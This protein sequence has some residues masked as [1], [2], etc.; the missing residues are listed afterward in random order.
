MNGIAELVDQVTDGLSQLRQ[1]LD[2][3]SA[4][5]LATITRDIA[6]LERAMDKKAYVDAAFAQACV[7]ADAGKL[8]GANHPDAYLTEKLGISRGEAYN[9][10]ARA[11]ALF[12]APPPPEPDLGDL[13]GDDDTEEDRSAAEE[14]AR[15]AA[16]EEAERRR[17]DQEEA[18]KRA[19]EVPAAKQDIIRRELD[20]LL[21]A[22]EGERMRIYAR[23][24]E[25]AK[26][27][28]EKDL[29]LFVKRLVAEA[30]KPHV[31]ANP[32]AGFEKRDASLGRE[33]SDGTFDVTLSMTR[34]DYA[35]YK[36]L[37]D[38]GLSP[39]ANIPAEL[40]RDRD[41]RTKGQRRYDQYMAILRQYEEGQQAAN[42]GAASVVVSITLDDLAGADANTLFQTNV[43]VELDAFD[44]VR[45]GMDGTSDF[46]L[47]VDG[48]SG[49]PLHLGRSRRL[50]SVG[51]R[52]AMFAVQG[53]CSWAGCT[54]SMSECEA[55][56]IISWLR[57]GATDIENLTGLCPT[58]HRCNNDHRD[59][60][61]NKGYMDYDP[62][63]GGAVLVKADGTRHT[64][65]TDPAMH[66][67]VNRIRAKRNS[68]SAPPPAETHWP[69]SPPPP[70][71]R[72][73]RA[74]HRPTHRMP[75]RP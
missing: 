2:D 7:L 65:T 6:R 19:D 22:A 4:L 18:R 62:E 31:K 9:R 42:G 29:R 59:G 39:N 47:T 10:L 55:H 36:A 73:G 3:P 45:L 23:A 68:T 28:D 24:M 21:K 61:F 11:K 38:K 51:Q 67:A 48:L 27:R 74:N 16:D 40:Q 75:M 14:A 30:N 12:D 63:T 13:F 37:T 44:L 25:Q 70:P 71:G 41:P 1:L 46:L 49:V 66:S 17:K 5:P 32:N 64:N 58:H 26:Y 35:L 20:K 33:N 34:A 50:A 53:V 69:T 57:Y 52:I 43:G 8:V 54:T 15:K 72:A 60:S 56:H